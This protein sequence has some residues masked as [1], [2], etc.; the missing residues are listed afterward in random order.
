MFPTDTGG[1]A[2]IFA[3][4]RLWDSSKKFSLLCKLA[5]VVFLLLVTQEP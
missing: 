3:Y 4:M 5:Q 1:Q 2:A